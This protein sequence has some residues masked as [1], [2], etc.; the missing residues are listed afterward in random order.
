MPTLASG[1]SMGFCPWKEFC[2]GLASF[3]G[4]VPSLK[5]MGQPLGT[6]ADGTTGEKPQK[7]HISGTSGEQIAVGVSTV[8]HPE[9][10]GWHGSEARG[11]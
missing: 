4:T 7:S 9:P 6:M 5:G 10:W 1:N 3:L 11:Q 2:S 8:T